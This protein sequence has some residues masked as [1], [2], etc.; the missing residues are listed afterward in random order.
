MYRH[1]HFPTPIYIADIEHPT[2]NQE[3]ERDIVAWSKQDKGITRTN[4]QGW[5]SPTNMAQLPQFK[6]LVDML[7][8]CQKTIYEQEHLDLEPVLGNMW[9]NINPP[10]G[11]N[12]AHQHPNSLWSGVYYIKAPKNCGHLKIDDPRASAAMYRPKQKE[13][14]VPERLFRE[15]HYEPVAGRCIMFPSW[16]MHCVDPN[17]SNDIRISV[18]FN[19]LQKGMFV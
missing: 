12:R 19:F 11:M 13:G 9:A 18:S 8:A 10:G 17:E 3:L 1:L 7:F 4:V 15:T 14:P 6:K 5:H 16:L 2:L